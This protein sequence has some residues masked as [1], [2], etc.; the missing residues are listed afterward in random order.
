VANGLRAYNL[1]R[2]R[3][4]VIVSLLFTRLSQLLEM[5][6]L[7]W[8]F[9]HLVY[10]LLTRTHLFLNWHVTWL[11]LLIIWLV[12]ILA[13]VCKWILGIQGMTICWSLMIVP[14]LALRGY[15]ELCISILLHSHGN[16]ISCRIVHVIGDSI[17]LALS[18][19]VSHILRTIE[20]KIATFVFW[21]S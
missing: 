8:R 19:G 21:R 14:I 15:S 2:D 1:L 6:L 7:T 10:Q 9:F 3:S 13:H 18:D 5:A 16:T 12:Q 11:S 20:I 4:Q 17:I